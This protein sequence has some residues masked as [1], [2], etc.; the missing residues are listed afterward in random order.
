VASPSAVAVAH[1]RTVVVGT[2]SDTDAP[3]IWTLNKRGRWIVRATAPAA[4]ITAFSGVAGSDNG[5]VAVGWSGPYEVTTDA[6][7][8][9]SPDGRSWQPIEGPTGPFAERTHLSGVI[10]TEREYLAFGEETSGSGTPDDPVRSRS[11][12][13]IRAR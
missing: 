3:V 11:V 10:A 9:T 6:L 4:P 8:W 5:F 2:Q 12:L 1:G 13:W 7:V